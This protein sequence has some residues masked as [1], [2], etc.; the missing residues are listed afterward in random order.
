MREN[1]LYLL[2]LVKFEVGGAK[3]IAFFAFVNLANLYLFYG[4]S[5]MQT[6]QNA[7]YCV[8]NLPYGKQSLRMLVGCVAN[9][10]AKH[11]QIDLFM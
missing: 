7:F 8:A 6:L 5:L 10:P 9:L 4:F 1:S 3:S 11:G 2:A